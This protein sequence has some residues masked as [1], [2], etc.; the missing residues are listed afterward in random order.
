LPKF[1]SFCCWIES[2]GCGCTDGNR[3]H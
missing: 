3:F 2:V 1:P